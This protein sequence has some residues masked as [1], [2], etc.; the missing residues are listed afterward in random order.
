MLRR[1]LF[2]QKSEKINRQ[3]DQWKLAMEALH[4]S[5]GERG[6]V[7]QPEAEVTP[8]SA[9]QRRPLPAH[10]PREIQTHL[11]AGNLCPDCGLSLASAKALGED[12]SEVLEY[13]PASFRV[14]RHVRPRLACSCGNCIAQAPVAQSPNCT[15]LCRC[16]L[17][18]THHGR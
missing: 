16:W 13:V 4:I 8:R 9:P 18:S 15:Q 6:P 17:T 12:I 2:G 10:L 1:K 5:K 3:I 14:I 7:Q 11:P